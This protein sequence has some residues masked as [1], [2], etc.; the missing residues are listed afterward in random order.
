MNICE[1]TPCRSSQVCTREVIELLLVPHFQKE[2]RDKGKRNISVTGEGPAHT[3]PQ[4]R[5]GAHGAP[6]ARGV[7]IVLVE[8]LQAARVARLADVDVAGTADAAMARGP[9]AGGGAG[10]ELLVEGDGGS[11]VGVVG[12]ASAT[13]AGE[14]AARGGG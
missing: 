8:A 13:D 12:V 9:L 4:L 10:A 2:K 14:E 7:L 1:G 5:L 3:C 6:A 11:L